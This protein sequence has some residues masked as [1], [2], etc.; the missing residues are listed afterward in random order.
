MNEIFDD[1]RKIIEEL[2]DSLSKDTL[3]ASDF[4]TGRFVEQD[5][6]IDTLQDL[7]KKYEG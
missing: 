5:I 7:I 2:K 1:L 6:M 4:E 3:G